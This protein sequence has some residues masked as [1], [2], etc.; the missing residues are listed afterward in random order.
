MP[1]HSNGHSKVSG[2]QAPPPAD[3][4]AIRQRALLILL[5]LLLAA[6]VLA[7]T[8]CAIALWRVGSELRES[9]TEL[10]KKIE[11]LSGILSVK[12]MFPRPPKPNSED[13]QW[14]K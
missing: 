13:R 9:G 12:E 1:Y 14:P 10:T 4:E 6:L 5:A 7:A 2:P 11:N 8:G 3:R